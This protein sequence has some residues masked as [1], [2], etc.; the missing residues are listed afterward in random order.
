MDAI[1]VTIRATDRE[2]RIRVVQHHNDLLVAQFGPTMFG[3]PRALPMLLEALALWFQQRLCVAVYAASEVIA[4][5][6]G[7]VDDL[8]CGL[9]TF[10]FIVD[11]EIGPS[12]R[13]SRRLRRRTSAAVGAQDDIEC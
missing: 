9:A 2:L 6:T 7:L 3:S 5:S 13:R 1:K 11:A 8:G 4:S 10:H 12:R